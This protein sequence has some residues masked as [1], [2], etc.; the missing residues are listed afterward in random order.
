MWQLRKR[1]LLSPSRSPSHTQARTHT[2]V[3]LIQ[4]MA[5][6]GKVAPG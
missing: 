3:D 2:V 1:N 5:A 6:S 4:Y